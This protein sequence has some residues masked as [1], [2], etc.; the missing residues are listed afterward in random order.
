MAWDANDGKAFCYTG[1]NQLGYGSTQG[2]SDKLVDIGYTSERYV[3]KSRNTVLQGFGNSHIFHILTHGNTGFIKTGSTSKIYYYDVSNYFDELPG[4]KF[5]FLE[6]CSV[7]ANNNFQNTLN[8]LGV[9][10]SLAFSS[11]ISA[12]TGSD[13][14][15]YFATRVYYYLS[16]NYSLYQAVINARSDVFSNSGQYWGSENAVIR[17]QYMSLLP[18]ISTFV[19]RLYQN[20]LERTP[21]SSG[22]ESWYSVLENHVSGGKQVAYGFV[23]SQEFINLGLNNTNYVKRL[24]RTLLGREAE[25]SG[26]NNWVSLLNN[27]AD[28][29]VVFNGIAGSQE[30]HS[31]C[32]LCGISY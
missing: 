19:N 3:N 28:R 14:I 12:V 16:N 18:D 13:G 15:H 10:S 17:G 4:L 6:S 5:V 23:F 31:F 27:G 1:E 2:I 21:D 20:C 8:T 7:A 26:L 25:P 9:E 29:L 32:D 24:Y 22:Y 11:T 30:F